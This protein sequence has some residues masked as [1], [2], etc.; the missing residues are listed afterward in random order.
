MGDEIVRHF[1]MGGVEPITVPLTDWQTS[2]FILQGD[3]KK[4]IGITLGLF[5]AANIGKNEGLILPSYDMLSIYLNEHPRIK[6]LNEL[7]GYKFFAMTLA[8]GEVPNKMVPKL[9]RQQL[10]LRDIRG[11]HTILLTEKSPEDLVNIYQEPK[12]GELLK[13]YKIVPISS[14]MEFVE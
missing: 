13:E 11:K 2:P 1:G 3:V 12:I 14:L 10:E 6:A 5:Q 4:G 7:L 8:W 9:I